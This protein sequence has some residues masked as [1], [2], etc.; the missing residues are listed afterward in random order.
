MAP[1]V[2]VLVDDEADGEAGPLLLLLERAQVVG[3]DLGQHRDDAVGEVDRVAADLRLAVEAGAGAHVVGDVGDGDVHDVAAGVAGI[4]VRGGVDGIVMVA[5]VDG[6][7]GDELEGAQVGAAGQPR[8]LE[9]VGLGQHGMRELVGDA[10]G[11]HGDQA[12]LALVLRVA[13]RLG[14]A[15]LRHAV[16]MRGGELEAHEV[17]GLGAALVAGSDRPLLELLAVDGIDEAAA[18]GLGAEDADQA[19]LGARQA[20]DGARLVAV[21]G[22]VLVLEAG[23]AGEDAVALAERGL[24]AGLPAARGQ[25][26]GARALAFG[27]IPHGG[28]GDQLA[29]GVAGHDLQHG[30]RAAACPRSLKP[31]RLPA[32]RPSAA[33]SPSSALRAMRSPPLMLKARAISRLPDLA[34]AVRR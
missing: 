20:L 19:P 13:E 25:H 6:I 11:V 23:D 14:D 21:A 2:A 10:V 30:R 4:V 33:I 31:L 9:L 28:L 7:D 12:D 8:R 17:A 3:D 16:A 5:R 1:L 24:A 27:G 32:S 15:R 18:A 29:V 22:D 26:Q 34:G